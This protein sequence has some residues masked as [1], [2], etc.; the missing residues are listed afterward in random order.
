[1]DIRKTSDNIFVAVHDWKKWAEQTKY[2]GDLPPDRNRFKLYKI[3]EK[4]TPMDINDI[5]HW[6]TTHPDATLVTD[7]INDPLEF[8]KNFVD[9]KRLIMELFTWDAV[10]N[11]IQAGIKSSMPTG[12]ILKQIKGDKIVFL[13][14][15]GI[16]DVAISRRSV[17]NQKQLLHKMVKSGIHIYAFLINYDEGID[18]KYVVCNERNYF[19][20][21]YADKWDFNTSL[22]CSQ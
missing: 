6:F 4:Y 13:K 11:G 17:N 10:K 15:L 20:G 2:T 7:K 8:S 1:M 5:N 22:N 19:Y 3:E 9:K 12:S 21:M 16:K 14:K 18:E